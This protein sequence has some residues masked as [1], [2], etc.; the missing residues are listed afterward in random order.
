MKLKKTK[1]AEELELIA[2]ISFLLPTAVLLT[3]PALWWERL[4]SVEVFALWMFGIVVT[5]IICIAISL[6]DES[7]KA[8]AKERGRNG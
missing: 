3:T 1:L 8:K 4:E 5:A 7:Q 6:Y 2:R